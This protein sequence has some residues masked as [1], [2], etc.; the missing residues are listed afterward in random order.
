MML[1]DD[2][3]FGII[4]SRRLRST[5]MGVI[6]NSVIFIPNFNKIRQ[7]VKRILG[8]DTQIHER[9]GT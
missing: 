1:S 6:S 4:Y 3:H 5:K 7:L 2:R 8:G 9:Y